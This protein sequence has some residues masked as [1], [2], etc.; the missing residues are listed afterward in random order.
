MLIKGFDS[1]TTKKMNLSEYSIIEVKDLFKDKYNCYDCPFRMMFKGKVNQSGDLF[2]S[3]CGLKY[4]TKIGINLVLSIS[5]LL[6][7]HPKN[8]TFLMVSV[9]RVKE[10]NSCP[11]DRHNSGE[12]QLSPELKK[13][14]D[15]WL[16][17][18][19]NADQAKGE[20]ISK[21]ELAKA[22]RRKIT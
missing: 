15:A 6:K 12:E 11:I 22:I 19:R 18:Y 4:V 10:L 2:R 13:R 1:E 8:E 5:D 14:F 16:E 20:A 9:I 7:L 17:K 3:Y 21:S